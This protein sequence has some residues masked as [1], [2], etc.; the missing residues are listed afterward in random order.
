MSQCCHKMRLLDTTFFC[1]ENDGHQCPHT[2]RFIES[3]VRRFA[4]RAERAEAERDALLLAGA[5]S[6]AA[7]SAAR[8]GEG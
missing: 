1:V 7:T 4:E 5:A 2:Y 3:D 6:M 8:K